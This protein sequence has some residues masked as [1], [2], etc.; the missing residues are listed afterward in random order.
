MKRRATSGGSLPGDSTIAVHVKVLQATGLAGKSKK[1]GIMSSDPYAILR[2]GHVEC[3]TKTKKGTLK[4]TFNE[5]FAFPKCSHEHAILRVAL[6][7]ADP[8]CHDHF[9]GEVI[10]PVCSLT[11]A[12]EEP[13]WRPLEVRPG[14]TEFVSGELC[15]SISSTDGSAAPPKL[16]MKKSDSMLASA[17]ERQAF[18]RTPFSRGY[19]IAPSELSFAAG[20]PLGQG[21]FGTVRQGFFRGLPVA[22]KT[23]IVRDGVDRAELIDEFRTEV[24][25]L[26]KVSHHPKLCLFLGASLVEPLSVV[27][28]LMVGSVRNLLDK[29]RDES[30]ALLTWERRVEMLLDAALG[31]SYLHGMAVVH[32]DMK[33]DNLLLDAHGTTKVADF[34]LSRTLTNNALAHTEVGTPGFKAPEIYE[35]ETDDGAA[36]GDGYSLPVDVFAFGCTIYE[37]LT[38]AGTN[39]GWP[40]GWALDLCTDEQV[41]KA[42]RARKPPSALGGTPVPKDCPAAL[43]SMYTSCVAHDAAKRP[44]F[45]AIVTELRGLLGRIREGDA[46]ESKATKPPPAK[47][48]KAARR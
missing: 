13:T 32:R 37:L 19:V 33:A 29:P 27:S 38:F 48:K 24:A 30:I 39:W 41:E 34:G 5:E 16:K 47:G 17:V 23:L 42:V 9:L 43:A 3:R 22:V 31:M 44:I 10:V 36:D 21:G 6:Y 1:G 20:K 7:T 45:E 46:P 14:S 15:L 35:G 11:A 40:Y 4:P 12:D 26:A 28:E 8:L 18:G 2:I 25:M